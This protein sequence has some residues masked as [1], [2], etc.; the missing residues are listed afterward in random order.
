MCQIHLHRFFA[1]DEW[2]PSEAAVQY[3]YQPIRAQ[4]SLPSLF[5]NTLRLLRTA[6]LAFTCSRLTIETLEQG[7]KYIQS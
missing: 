7:V 3:C 1:L 5:H 6:Q 2:L 4:K